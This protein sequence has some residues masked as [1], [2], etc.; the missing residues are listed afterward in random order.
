MKFQ[1]TRDELDAILNGLGVQCHWEHKGG[2]EMA[3]IDDGVSNL[4]LNWWPD[5]GEIQLVGD[6]AQRLP[7]IQRLEP[8]LA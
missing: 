5:S 7:L 4:K 8:L 2:F 1:G 3:V 6:P